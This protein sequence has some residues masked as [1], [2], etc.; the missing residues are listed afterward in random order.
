MTH[1]I[2]PAAG[3]STRFPGMKPKYLLYDYTG[4]PM[5]VRAMKSVNPTD[6]KSMTI[7]ILQE[8]IRKWDAAAIIQHFTPDVNIHILDQPTNGPVQTVLEAI[9]A[10]GLKFYDDPLYI[11]DCDS[12][13]DPSPRR[14]QNNC[15]YIAD[16]NDI[17]AKRINEKSFVRINEHGYVMEIAEKEI[18]SKYICVGGYQFGSCRKF[19]EYA[20]NLCTSSQN[21]VYVSSVIE[22][23]LNDSVFHT[24]KVT[25]YVDV[26]TAQ[27]WFDYND[28]PVIFC[29]IDG[30]IFENQNR[31]GKN[32]YTYEPIPIMDN[33]HVIQEYIADDC[34]VIFTTSRPSSVRAITTKNLDKYFNGEYELIM[35][36]PNS[37][38]ILV[39]D[40]STGYPYP[41]ATAVNL[42][43]NEGSLGDFL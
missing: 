15:V 19:S 20:H 14:A 1:V 33:I 26:G 8:H 43:R 32:N 41:R 2:M 28:K 35:D 7:V 16:I 29:D 27:E 9:M 12:F 34:T 22:R 23:M 39:N 4:T 13:Y 37:R 24:E 21:E 17:N 38:R 42:K 31:F 5:Y 10:L 25:G 18:I 36:L 30:V 11:K 40:Y 6:V 3:R